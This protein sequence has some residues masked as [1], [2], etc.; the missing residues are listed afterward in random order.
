M[1]PEQ[2]KNELPLRCW[3]DIGVWGNGSCVELPRVGHCRNCEVYIAGSREL[4]ERPAPDDY[5]DWWTELLAGKTKDAKSEKATSYLVFRIGQSWLALRA[6]VLRE[7]MQPAVIRSLPHRRSNVLLGLTVVRGEIYPCV[8]LHALIADET[9]D[10][11]PSRRFLVAC[12]Q[13]GD[14]VVPV[15][16]VSG[17]YDVPASSIESL[18]A[19]LA[20]SGSVYTTGIAQCGD[21]PVGL[22]DE[23]LLFSTLERKIA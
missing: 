11:S 8:S 5:M 4:L 2:P 10:A 21:R 18:P 17:I 13:G 7:I 20:H 6:L 19:T 14:W 15:D 22:I 23:G 12:H 16:E 3:G 1:S 9:Q